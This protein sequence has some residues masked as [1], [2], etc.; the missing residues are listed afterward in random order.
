MG[1]EGK[2]V[3]AMGTSLVGT[4]FLVLGYQAAVT[5]ENF[6]L[7]AVLQQHQSYDNFALMKLAATPRWTP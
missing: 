5:S 3:K 4:A 1:V 7:V 2:L 6:H